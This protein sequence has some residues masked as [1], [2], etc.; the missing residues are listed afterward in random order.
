MFSLLSYAIT[1]QMLPKMY[2]IKPTQATFLVT[3]VSII[4][5][6]IMPWFYSAFDN[7]NSKRGKYRS[8]ISFMAPLLALLSILS[9]FAPQFSHLE[10][11][12]TIRTMPKTTF[13][14]EKL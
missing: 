7:S 3:L 12:Q 6:V 2:G 4:Q 8:F 14:A 5:L 10:N 11:S 9:T 1:A 13:K